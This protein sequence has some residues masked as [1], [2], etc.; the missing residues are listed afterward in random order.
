MY[1][2]RIQLAPSREESALVIFNF[3]L[4]ILARV[5]TDTCRAF[6]QLLNAR[7]VCILNE[8]ARHAFNTRFAYTHIL[9]ARMTHTH[10]HWRV[11]RG[12]NALT[13]ARENGEK[14]KRDWTFV[15]VYSKKYTGFNSR[16]K[17]LTDSKKSIIL[18]PVTFFFKSAI[19]FGKPSNLNYVRIHDL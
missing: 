9:C 8:Y 4:S 13:V 7:R 15:Y 10:T 3:H 6:S 1:S 5:T 18:T 19:L 11:K 2:W 14:L 16:G 12:E 17:A